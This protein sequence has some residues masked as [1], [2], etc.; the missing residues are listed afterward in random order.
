MRIETEDF[1]HLIWWGLT[2]FRKKSY[3]MVVF[4]T[5]E[6]I[7]ISSPKLHLGSSG[8]YVE[9]LDSYPWKKKCTTR[10]V[11]KVNVTP[12]SIKHY[13]V[14]YTIH[15]GPRHWMVQKRNGSFWWGL[16]SHC[17]LQRIILELAGLHSFKRWLVCP[18]L[19]MGQFL[20]YALVT[21]IFDWKELQS[22]K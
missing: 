19:K 9:N 14:L 6:Q 7:W 22:V 10:V 17:V 16:L 1:S 2:D 15:Y 13:T 11:V 12:N 8:I 20:C 21:N 4:R 18:F 3:H 5:H